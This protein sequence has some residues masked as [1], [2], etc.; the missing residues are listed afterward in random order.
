MVNEFH[1]INNHLHISKISTIPVGRIK[2]A[3]N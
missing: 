3:L 2:Y 1:T